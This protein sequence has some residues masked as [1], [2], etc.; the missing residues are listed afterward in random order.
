MDVSFTPCLSTSA[1]NGKQLE[2][3][4]RALRL[5]SI[6][7]KAKE[8]RKDVRSLPSFSWGSDCYTLVTAACNKTLQNLE[9]WKD[10]IV[11]TDFEK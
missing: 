9:E 2:I 10:V 8:R 3:Q 1:H 11:S 7:S 6:S 5:S 4:R